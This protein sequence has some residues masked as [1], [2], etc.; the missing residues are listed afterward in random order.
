[1]NTQGCEQTDRVAGKLF[2]CI[3]PAYTPH[4]F[5]AADRLDGR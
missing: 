4:W 3:A 1:M 5:V 2:V